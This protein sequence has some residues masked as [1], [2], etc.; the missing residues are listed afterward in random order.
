MVNVVGALASACL[1][2]L[3]VCAP[4]LAFGITINF[5]FGIL[6]KLAPQIPVYF[7]STPFVVGGGLL[8][9][10]FLS[11]EMFAIFMFR[12]SDWLATG[13]TQ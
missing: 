6:N 2:A 11:D 7:V 9:M 12:F 3:Q 1:L 4:F 13:Q 10:Y 5:V 8:L